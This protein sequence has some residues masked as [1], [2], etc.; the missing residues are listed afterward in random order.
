MPI[1]KLFFDGYR[2]YIFADNEMLSKSIRIEMRGSSEPLEEGIYSIEADEE[3]NI[4]A[5]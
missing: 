5:I 2:L 1:A 4:H 3:G